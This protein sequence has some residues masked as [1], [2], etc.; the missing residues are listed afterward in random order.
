VPLAY[1][2]QKRRREQS[3]PVAKPAP[4]QVDSGKE[5]WRDDASLCHSRRAPPAERDEASQNLEQKAPATRRSLLAHMCALGG[6]E[7]AAA[8][9]T[10]SEI[11]IKLNV[12]EASRAQWIITKIKTNEREK[13]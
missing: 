3:N 11:S 8:K 10:Q 2:Q 4:P 1:D 6:T 9:I 5:A 12:F 13:S 7:L